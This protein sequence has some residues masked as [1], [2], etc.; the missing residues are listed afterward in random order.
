MYVNT[1]Y[2]DY[3]HYLHDV[4][5]DDHKNRF[6]GWI[7][8]SKGK[9]VRT[10]SVLSGVVQRVADEYDQGY[11]MAQ[12]EP[13][14]G[15]EKAVDENIRTLW[16]AENNRDSL[17]LEV[18]LGEV[19]NVNAVQVNFHDFNAN[20]FGRPD[21]IRQQFLIETSLNGNDWQVTVDF[22][23]NNEDHPH[24]YIELPEVIEARHVRF[25]NIYFPNQYLAI[26]DFRVFG[27]GKGNPPARPS[28]FKV[29]RQQDQRNA[30]L[31]W[32]PVPG[33][34]GYVI[35]WG[36]KKDR[37]N[38]SAMIYDNPG[39]ELRALN[40]GIPYYYRVE[41]FNENGISKNSKILSD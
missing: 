15:P 20:V 14:Y 10:N 25:K 13:D 26:S 3:P 2:G 4:K 31:S 36:I 1:A 35:Y 7:L 38:N 40:V 5:V 39:Y 37:L 23:D 27:K 11:M 41:A 18:D 34:I 17:F 32:K 21:T 24:A 30:D 6:T 16:V 12:E 8:L 19:M 9:K 29:K 28:D 33:A 22:S